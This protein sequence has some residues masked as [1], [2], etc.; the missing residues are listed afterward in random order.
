VATERLSRRSDGR[1]LY[2]LR[3]RWRDGTTHMLF[4][5]SE[6]IERLAVLVPPP[7]SHTVRYHGI[8]APAATCRDQVLPRPS[9][10]S[11]NDGRHAGNDELKAAPSKRRLSWSKLL[12]R[13]F[14]VDVLNCPRCGATMRLMATIHAPEAVRK[15]LGCLG[16]AS[17]PPPIRRPATLLAPEDQDWIEPA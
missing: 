10:D 16:L 2:R 9:T 4:E 1:L 14:A 11:D 5:P 13:V 15:I 6:L 7:R 3:H 17:R 8:L 12:A